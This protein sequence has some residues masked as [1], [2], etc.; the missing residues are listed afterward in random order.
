MVAAAQRERRNRVRYGREGELVAVGFDAAQRGCGGR[1][2]RC[3]R[4]RGAGIIAAGEGGKWQAPRDRSSSCGRR[5]PTAEPRASASDAIP[6]AT[7][8][9]RA[10]PPAQRTRIPPSLTRFTAFNC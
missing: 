5:S 8:A 4:P 6:Y 9:R 3:E 7:V 1:A 2:A 10:P